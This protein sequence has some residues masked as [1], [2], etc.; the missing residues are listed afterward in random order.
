MIL[1]LLLLTQVCLLIVISS[2]AIFYW[3][4]MTRVQQ[5]Q[6]AAA[7]LETRKLIDKNISR[8]LR[9]TYYAA[10]MTSIILLKLSFDYL[11]GLLFFAVL[12]SSIALIADMIIAMKVNIPINKQINSW[13]KEDIPSNWEQ[14]RARWLITYRYRQAFS[15]IGLLSLLLA[16]LFEN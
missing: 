2:Q 8:P 13:T 15:I 3:L 1:K 16:I 11:S 12:I 9:I 6:S 7:Y 5:G 4:V 10:L 14:I